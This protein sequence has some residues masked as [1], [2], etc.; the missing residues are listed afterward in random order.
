M[1]LKQTHI[2]RHNGHVSSEDRAAL[3]GQRPLTVWLTGLS[4]SG[5]STVGY[6]LERRLL[7]LGRACYVLDGDNLRH[8]LNCDLGFSVAERRENI[9]RTAEMAKLLNG[10]GLIVIAALISPSQD[11][12]AMAREIIGDSRFVEIY[13][14]TP[15]STCEQRDPKGLYA[16][17]RCG[18]IAEFT[19]VSAPYEIPGDP[20]LTFDT[21]RT[22]IHASVSLI[23]EYLQSQSWPCPV[24]ATRGPSTAQAVGF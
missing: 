16:R 5:K 23:V 14:S 8:G 20:D 17:A 12:R 4:A 3:L 10:A 11:D 21:S 24:E 6:A 9:R 15:L 18:D 2:K 19:G 1:E 13:L 7:S 22:D